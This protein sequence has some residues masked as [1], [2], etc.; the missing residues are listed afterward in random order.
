VSQRP[1]GKDRQLFGD[2]RAEAAEEEDGEDPEVGE[3]LD[4]IVDHGMYTLPVW[5]GRRFAVNPRPR[6]QAA[7]RFSFRVQ[8]S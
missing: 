7:S 1:G 2:G 4:E 6:A 5:C 8:G 3:L